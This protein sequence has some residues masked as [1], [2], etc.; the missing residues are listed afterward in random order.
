MDIYLGYSLGYTILSKS[1]LVVPENVV[2]SPIP[3]NFNG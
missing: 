1:S 2:Y 3:G